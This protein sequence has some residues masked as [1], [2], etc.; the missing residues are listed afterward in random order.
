MF[1]AATPDDYG[2]E[3]YDLNSAQGTVSGSNSYYKLS[4]T[5]TDNI[6]QAIGVNK[7]NILYYVGANSNVTQYDIYSANTAG[8]FQGATNRLALANVGTYYAP[9]E[10]AALAIDQSDKAWFVKSYPNNGFS[11][12]GFDLQ[13]YSFMTN[14]AGDA[15]NFLTAGKILAGDLSF[16]L[17]QD[18]AFDNE[19]NMF[20]LVSDG[21][22]YNEYT[23]YSPGFTSVSYYIYKLTKAQLDDLSLGTDVTMQRVWQITWSDGT[24]VQRDLTGIQMF[25]NAFGQP[26]LGGLA[27][28]AAGKLIVSASDF[29]DP[30][31]LSGVR[32]VQYIYE[33]TPRGADAYVSVTNVTDDKTFDLGM[34]RSNHA[35]DL[36]TN[37]FPT[38]LPV[39]FGAIK[40]A[41]IG[42]QLKLNWQTEQELNVDYFQVQ[43]STNGTDF[44]N[45]G[46]K[47]A[48]KAVNGRSDITINYEFIDDLENQ[49]QAA[50]LLLPFGVLLLVIGIVFLAKGNFTR[51]KVGLFTMALM[52]MSGWG[53]Q[54]GGDQGVNPDV[55]ERLYVRIMQK[56][57]DGKESYSKV[58]SVYPEK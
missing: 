8:S 5:Y 54:K 58:I 43:G 6:D 34:Q 37:I 13:A 57:K 35:S 26:I 3:V 23:F 55:V 17:I 10:G 1:D 31:A 22:P 39:H 45:L 12:T 47:I 48:S 28:T 29:Q 19:D 2:Y 7:Y 14:A 52:L 50:G 24:P 11:S 15:T 33:L 38:A 25:T 9:P 41:I 20:L 42:N 16:S 56:D 40:G 27:F 4:D 36:A 30:G 44:Y 51:R 18:I 46:E 21:S 32:C 49:T 53:C